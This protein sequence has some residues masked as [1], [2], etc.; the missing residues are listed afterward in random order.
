MDGIWNL[1]SG[2]FNKMVER[3]INIT[4]KMGTVIVS[5]FLKKFGCEKEQRDMTCVEKRIIEIQ[6]LL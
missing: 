4:W 1:S 6:I 5:N 3:E 2:H